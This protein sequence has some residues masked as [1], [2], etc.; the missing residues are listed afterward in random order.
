MSKRRRT[1]GG[2]V[3]GGTG[4]V[5]P[6]IIS[7]NG[8]HNSGSIFNVT[9]IPLPR[10]VL[11]FQKNKA[12]IYELLKIDWYLGLT[13][14]QDD[15]EFVLG[16]YLHTSAI[17]V[18]GATATEATI[19]EDLGDSRTIGG[20]YITRVDEGTVSQGYVFGQFTMPVTIDLTDSNGNGILFAEDRLGITLFGL[21]LATTSTSSFKLYYRLVNIGLDEFVGLTRGTRTG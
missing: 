16:G 9:S 20:A 21:G 2:S 19:M 6:Q 18:N 14:V 4:D 3:T 7:F 1:S 13:T 8:S 11:G 5:K 15:P 17:R 12:I 10:P